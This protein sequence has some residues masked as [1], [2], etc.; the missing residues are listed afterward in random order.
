MEPQSQLQPQQQP[1]TRAR[2]RSEWLKRYNAMQEAKKATEQ[3]TQPPQQTEED[4]T[5]DADSVIISTPAPPQLPMSQ[6]KLPLQPVTNINYRGRRIDDILREKDEEV[7]K[8]AAIN[9]KHQD[10]MELLRKL[11][12]VGTPSPA[13]PAEQ[14]LPLKSAEQPKSDPLPAVQETETRLRPEI[15]NALSKG[16]GPLPAVREHDPPS[17][18]EPTDVHANRRVE[19]KVAQS[20]LNHTELRGR[21]FS[22]PIHPKSALEAILQDAKEGKE[23]HDY[24]D[25]TIASLEN[26]IHPNTDP[27][28]STFTN[29]AI[30]PKEEE[31]EKILTQT[32]KDRRQENLALEAMS[33][34]LNAT[35]SNL[36]DANR[37]LRRIENRIEASGETVQPASQ[38][39][40]PQPPQPPQQ[41]PPQSQSPPQPLQQPQQPLIVEAAATLPAGQTHN[42]NSNQVGAVCPHCGHAASTSV[43]QSLWTELRQNF[44]TYDTSS[45]IHLTWLGW[46]F[47]LWWIWFL[48]E[49]LLCIEYCNYIDGPVIPF[50]TFNLAV[51][52]FLPILRP[53]FAFLAWSFGAFFNLLF[54]DVAASSKPATATATR[55]NLLHTGMGGV[56]G[57]TTRILRASATRVSQSTI[58]A[59]DE[60]GSLW[61]DEM[62]F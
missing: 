55:N 26:I 15:S 33:K 62:I 60:A 49:N 1:F 44:Y 21:V 54:G 23:P 45:H 48:F 34:R 35:S 9:K 22:E 18:R 5:F 41:Q 36:K 50:V 32:E 20:G 51:Q 42:E 61:D 4:L 47:V 10:S 43:W 19:I 37:G 46:T 7:A 53:L 14:L 59:L 3:Q 40:A 56:F 39:P 27:T 29:D 57:T 2:P 12:R 24:G 30:T 6:T 58:D 31:E 16:K 52:P 11:S 25:D 13:K 8:Q 28:N 38:R 17:K